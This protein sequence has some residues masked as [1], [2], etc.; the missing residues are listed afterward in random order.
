MREDLLPRLLRRPRVAPQ[1]LRGASR[2]PATPGW[3]NARSYNSGGFR[4]RA[5]S[6]ATDSYLSRISGGICRGALVGARFAF[7]SLFSD[8]GLAQGPHLQFWW[9]L[10][11]GAPCGRLVRIF[12]GFPVVFVGAP[13]VGARFAFFFVVPRH[14]A[15]ARPA[16]TILVVSGTGRPLWALG[17]YFSRIS[18]GICRG[19]PCGRPVCIFS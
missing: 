5:P 14:R 17:S 8:T 12:R 3:R 4:R 18:G 16:L 10:V 7:F 1:R 19:A 6:G 11:G 15:G 2:R 9:F 13:L